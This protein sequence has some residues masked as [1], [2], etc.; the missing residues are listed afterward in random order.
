MK[1]QIAAK[2][3]QMSNLEDRLLLKDV[4]NDVFLNLYEHSET[5]YQQL[6]DRVFSEMSGVSDSYDVYT[7]VVS[8]QNLDPVHYFLRP[9]QVGDLE[10]KQVNL[11]AIVVDAIA[12]PLLQVFFSCDYRMLASIINGGRIFHGT[13]VTNLG[14]ITAEFILR[15]DKRYLNQIN[16]LYETFL[17]N[18]IPWRTINNPYAFRFAE[19]LMESC[20]RPLENDETVTQIQVDFG[21][22]GQYVHYDMVP[23]WNVELLK[24]KSTGFPLPCEDKINFEHMVPL[25]GIGIEHGYLAAFQNK[26]IS[27]VRRTKQALVIVAPTE[28]KDVWDIMRIIHPTG[29]KTDVYTYPLVSNAKRQAFSDILAQKSLRVIRTEAELRRLIGSFAAAANFSLSHI[30]IQPCSQEI[31]NVASYEMNCF[32][33]DEIRRA[34]CQHRLILNFTTTDRDSLFISD[35]MSFLVSEVQLYYPDYKCEG[36]LL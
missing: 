24:L 11:T 30:A 35:R 4:L 1:E 15:E 31:E 32:I 36:V 12:E 10:E 17:N 16:E 2:L 33:Q 3:N 13:I 28:L 18:N 23:L 8:R 29:G 9:M 6:E 7:T 5:M 27:Y 34:D 26:N 25:E 21:E 20:Q 19:V 22:Y 14:S